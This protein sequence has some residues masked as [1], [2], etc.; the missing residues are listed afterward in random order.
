[1]ILNEVHERSGRQPATGRSTS[2]LLPVIPLTLKQV[3]ILGGRDE[4]LWRSAVV[5]VVGFTVACQ[6]HHGRMV[7]II[8]PQSVCA[9]ALILNLFDNL[10]FLWFVLRHNDR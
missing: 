2:L 6:S 4:L 10:Y 5:G 8:V 1:M 9:V 7:K 3:A